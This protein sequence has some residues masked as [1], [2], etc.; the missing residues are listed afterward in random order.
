MM[1]L[2]NDRITRGDCGILATFLLPDPNSLILSM[3]S[4]NLFRLPHIFCIGNS[5]SVL[6]LFLWKTGK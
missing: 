1:R 4:L 2:R 5:N 6:D 3:T